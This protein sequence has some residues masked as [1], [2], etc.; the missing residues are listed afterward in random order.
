M[1]GKL[2]EIVK[3]LGLEKVISDNVSSGRS[4]GV[5]N[6]DLNAN[7]PLYFQEQARS[8][9]ETALQQLEYAQKN[10]EAKKKRDAAQ[11][12]A[13]N[14]M[15]DRG[16]KPAYSKVTEA[17]LKANSAE[18]EYQDYINSD[19]YRQRTAEREKKLNQD[20][21]ARSMLSGM[22]DIPEPT[23][24]ND[25]KEMQLRAFAER[26]RADADAAESEEIMQTDLDELAAWSEEDRVALDR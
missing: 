5:T 8:A 9:K 15:W 3:N 16:N 23:I 19:E 26:A 6:D 24:V 1:A 11:A 12:E 14:Q 25:E 4:S 20:R 18:K 2:D 13:A 21:L 17:K 7:A 10:Q 22:A